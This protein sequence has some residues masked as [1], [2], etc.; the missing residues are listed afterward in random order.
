MTWLFLLA[1]KNI[2]SACKARSYH[3]YPAR[4]EVQYRIVRNMI[5]IHT[6]NFVM[7]RGHK[8]Q[9]I[10]K[11][12]VSSQYWTYFYS[13]MCKTKLVLYTPLS[14][15]VRFVRCCPSHNGWWLWEMGKKQRS[16]TLSCM[17]VNNGENL[18]ANQRILIKICIWASFCGGPFH[19][20]NSR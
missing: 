7:N 3:Y 15:A 8:Q 13:T 20:G 6:K 5:F 9:S 14:A 17:I 11:V 19:S 10:L 1:S 2:N 12:A 16:P 4:L 18:N